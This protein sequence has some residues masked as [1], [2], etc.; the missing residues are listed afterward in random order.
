LV[1][2]GISHLAVCQ[3]RKIVQLVFS[4]HGTDEVPNRTILAICYFSIMVSDQF[5]TYRNLLIS[6]SPFHILNPA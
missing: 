5:N 1:W 2:L 3:H 4:L 6:V